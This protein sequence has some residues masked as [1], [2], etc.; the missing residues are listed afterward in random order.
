MVNKVRFRGKGCSPEMAQRIIEL[1]L[2]DSGVCGLLAGTLE[3][4]LDSPKRRQDLIPEQASAQAQPE[5]TRRRCRKLS[6]PVVAFLHA[7]RE[8][9]IP[10]LLQEVQQRFGVTLSPGS[11]Y[12]AWKLPVSSQQSRSA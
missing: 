1:L 4:R 6:D 10:D 2:N 7:R 3:S 8:L 5:K 11:V 9:P 12:K